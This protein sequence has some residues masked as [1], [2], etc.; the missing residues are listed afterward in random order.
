MSFGIPGRPWESVGS[1]II[2]NDNKPY[3]YVVD[4]YS[5]FPV[6]KQVGE[7]QCRKPNTN[8]Q[9]YLFRIWDTW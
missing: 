7:I 4:Y 9:D 1:D 3:L 6:V 5:K 2:V 8:M